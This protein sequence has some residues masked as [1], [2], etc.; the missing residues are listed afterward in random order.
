[1]SVGL[2]VVSEYKPARTQLWG[3]LVTVN[4][5]AK[6]YRSVWTAASSFNDIGLSKRDTAGFSVV[7]SSLCVV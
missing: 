1:M 5:V 7:R 4:G 6:V 2:K 3:R